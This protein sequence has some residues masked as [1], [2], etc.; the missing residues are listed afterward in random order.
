[1]YV[2]ATNKSQNR[3]Q[4]QINEHQISKISVEYGVHVPLMLSM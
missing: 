3:R 4:M 1:M 2:T